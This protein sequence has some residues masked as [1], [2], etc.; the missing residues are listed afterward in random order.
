MYQTKP[1]MYIGLL[2]NGLSPVF[3]LK[4][5]I[6]CDIYIRLNYMR[7]IS[8]EQM[9]LYYLCNSLSLSNEKDIQ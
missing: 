6:Q 9:D 1:N 4:T 2:D 3:I 7:N 5:F 8:H